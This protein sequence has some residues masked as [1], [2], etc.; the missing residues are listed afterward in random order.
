MTATARRL[1]DVAWPLALFVI[2]LATFR[3]SAEPRGR[4]DSIDCE[5]PETLAMYP[6]AF[7]V[8]ATYELAGGHLTIEYTVESGKSNASEMFFSIGNH[9][10]C[11]GN[12]NCA[13][14]HTSGTA[15]HYLAIFRQ[16]NGVNSPGLRSHSHQR[17]HL[18]RIATDNGDVQFT[19][20]T[21]GTLGAQMRGSCPH[22]VEHNRNAQFVC[23]FPGA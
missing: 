6:F 19:K 7:T 4:D 14:K 15:R 12:G 17:P 3:G 8:D 10:A 21:Q 18:G 13:S 22:R 5:S 20:Q 9:I 16:R 2:F 1:V 11:P 23:S